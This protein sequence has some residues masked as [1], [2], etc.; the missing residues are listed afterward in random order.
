MIPTELQNVA[1]AVVR[2]AERQGFVLPRDIRRELTHTGIPE[3]QWKKVVAMSSASL[4]LREGRYY[5]KPAVSARMRQERRQQRAIQN[6]VRQLVRH[7]KKSQSEV[8]RRQQGRIEFVQPVK[9]R[10]DGQPEITLLSRDLSTSGIRLIGTRSFL[11]QKAHLSIPYGE[12]GE[13]A[14]LSVRFLWT[15]AVADGLFENGAV[16]LEVAREPHEMLRLVAGES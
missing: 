12:N 8:E 9:V 4:R 3:T 5:F 7:Y 16:F 2:R 6:A 13:S 11:G 1:N 10:I 15:C 14:C